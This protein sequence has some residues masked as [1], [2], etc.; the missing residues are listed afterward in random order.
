MKQQN[1]AIFADEVIS[2][3]LKD[4]ELDIERR[5]KEL[6]VLF[7]RLH[8]IL[9]H[10]QTLKGSYSSRNNRVIS[11]ILRNIFQFQV[12]EIVHLTHL[13]RS[14][15]RIYVERRNEATR[16]D[17]EF[18]ITFDEDLLH[19]ELNNDVNLMADTVLFEESFQ[20]NNTLNVRLQRQ[21]QKEDSLKLDLDINAQMLD[22]Y[23]EMNAIMKS[24]AE[25][26]QIFHEVNTLVVDQGSALDRI[27]YNIEQVEHSVEVGAV[28]LEKA[29]RSIQKMRKMKI[30]FGTGLLLFLI[31]LIIILR[32]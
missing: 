8:S 12:Q 19:R 3:L 32:S 10:F 29:H 4:Y 16:I 7:T 2:E 30:I 11:S 9:T 14:C 15:Q 18:V 23:H 22:R 31:L 13:F 26:N 17:P 28:S 6:N 25:L 1:T 5:C 27:D 24:F 21:I 20:P